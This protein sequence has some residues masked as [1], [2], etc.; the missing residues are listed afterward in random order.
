[1]LTLDELHA[2]QRVSGI[3]TSGPVTIEVVNRHGPDTVSVIFTDNQGNVGRQLLSR[4]DEERLA[5]AMVA[6]LPPLDADA[7]EFKLAAESHRIELAYL[8]DPLLAVNTS[9]VEPLPHQISAVYEH[10]LSR[11]PLR[12]LLADDPGAGKTI[13]AGLFIKELILRGDVERCLIVVPGNLAEQWQDELRDKFQ[14]IFEIMTNDQLAAAASGNWL[15]EHDL[16]IARLDKLSRDEDLRPKLTNTEWD[17]I[18]FD[19]AHKLS[20]S[21]FG[22]EIKYTKRFLLARELSGITR[23]L[24]LMTATPHN[25]KEEDFQ[26]FLSLLDGDRFEGRPR[27]GTRQVDCSDLMRRLIKEQLVRFDGSPLFPERRAYTVGYILSDAE[28]QL[29]EE[30]TRYVREE[31]NRADRLDEKRRGTV[32]FALTVLQRRLASSPAAIHSS[33]ERRRKRLEDQLR[34]QRLILRGEQVPR[35]VQPTV[36]RWFSEED[37]D[38]L[39]DAPDAEVEEAE[40]MVLLRASTAETIDELN[41]EI[42]TLT[43]LESLA[44]AVVGSDRDRKWQELSRIIQDEDLMYDRNG[45]RRKLVIFTEHRDTLRYLARKITDMLGDPRAVVTIAGGMAREERRATEA[46]FKQEKETHI[47]VATDA[48]GEGINLQ[49]AHLMINYDLPWNPNRL[50][51][52]FGRIHRI[53]QTE[54]CHLWNLVATETREGQVFQ[55]LLE[56]LVVESEALGGRVFDIMGTLFEGHLLRDLMIKAIRAGDEGR[57]S[58]GTAGALAGVLGELDRTIHHDRLRELMEETALAF[59]TLDSS[60]VQAIRDQMERAQL[61][62]LQPFYIHA[63]FTAA[64]ADL[65]GVMRSREQ[66]RYEIRN[67]PVELRRRDRVI[68]TGAPLLP[69][70]ERITFHHDQVAA[71]DGRIAEL[72]GPGHPLLATV[73]DLTLEK[74]RPHLR[75]GTVFIDRADDADQGIRAM[76]VL[77]HTILEGFSTEESRRRAASA[78]LMTVWISPD[79]TVSPAGVA[80]WLDLDAPTDSE[81]TRARECIEREWGKQDLEA[82][83]ISHAA[84]TLAPEHLKE[85]TTR[86]TAQ[87]E[88]ARQQ[89]VARLSLEIAHWDHRAEELRLQEQAGKT[90]NRINAENARRRAE[91]LQLRLAERTRELENQMALSSQVPVIVSIAMVVPQ[92]LLVSD[93][94]D[95]P[96]P[97]QSVDPAARKRIEMIAMQAV[98][99]EETKRGNTPRDVSSENRGYDIESRRPDGT[100]LFLE[101]KG[102]V[103]TA[104]KITLTRNEITCALNE[105]WRFVLAIVLVHTNDTVSGLHYVQNCITS[106]PNWGQT[107]ADFQIATLLSRADR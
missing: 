45:A 16:V 43:R 54:I 62:K 14:L 32:G 1:M 69:R 82:L 64:F 76:V 29:Y 83:A 35:T 51:Q 52:R 75:T 47:L 90:N 23:H 70:Y 77:R 37:L 28:A 33:L 107:A 55:R 98:M 95:D 7:N 26:L 2:Q 4:A 96:T 10:M 36:T 88:K 106:E 105:P 30:V 27:D 13:M 17:L 81:I 103:S 66:N 80:P 87:I 79:G 19:E 50:E 25:G 94:P 89:I 100:L 60:R 18:I 5:P 61:Q 6:N 34:E 31:F 86:R 74:Y 12:Y 49:R 93:D 71:G 42:Q 8:Y 91:D 48:A 99:E 40:E 63:Y 72:I 39:D 73:L 68:G 85:V 84:S 78:R 3:A 20:A 9:S 101:V 21:R 41:A 59:N 24:L 65:K 22:N 57:E 97:Y 46:R 15:G 53:G 38:D 44:Q 11:Q 104:D 67:V 92:H 102:R 56:K 58:D